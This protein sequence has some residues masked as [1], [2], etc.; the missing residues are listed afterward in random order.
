MHDR[1][2]S[3]PKKIAIRDTPGTAD[4]AALAAP[5][6]GRE[7]MAELT[8]IERAKLV[9]LDQIRDDL[10]ALVCEACG[11]VSTSVPVPFQEAIYDLRRDRNALGG[12]FF[13]FAHLMAQRAPEIGVARAR[14]YAQRGALLMLAAVDVLLPGD[15]A[16][17][18][19][20]CLAL[21]VMGS[22]DDAGR[23]REWTEAEVA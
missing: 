18:S 6:T 12:S 23:W 5:R 4:L 13:R 17:A 19:E 7:R 20:P 11:R 8:E 16:P 21:P 10:R 22:V 15:D 1:R 9:A 2:R 14:D 3:T